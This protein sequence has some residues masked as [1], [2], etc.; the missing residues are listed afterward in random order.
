MFLK[1]LVI[2]S[3]VNVGT[4][5]KIMSEKINITSVIKKSLGKKSKNIL[6]E[7][8]TYGFISHRFP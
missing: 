8:K 5:N 1:I 4:E 7:I 3:L 6:R 2:F